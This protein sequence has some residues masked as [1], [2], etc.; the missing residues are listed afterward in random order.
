MTDDII[1][2]DVIPDPYRLA[3][4]VTLWADLCDAGSFRPIPIHI[5]TE[6]LGYARIHDDYDPHLHVHPELVDAPEP[7]QRWVLAHQL[8]HLARA[9]ASERART[10]LVRKANL[11][12]A[13]A[14]LPTVAVLAGPAIWHPIVIAV[15]LAAAAIGSNRLRCLEAAA[16]QY[17]AQILGVP[18]TLDAVRWLRPE[19]FPWPPKLGRFI[20]LFAQV[21]ATEPSWRF[22]LAAHAPDAELPRIGEVTE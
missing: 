11:A 6:T 4:F 3:R 2:T 9:D 1:R 16:D 5:D 17:A 18:L 15:G 22:R 21:W 8:S 13:L 7:A 12:L 20:R 10:A 14:V 19:P